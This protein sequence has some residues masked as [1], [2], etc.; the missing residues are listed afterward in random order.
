MD[1]RNES[2]NRSENASHRKGDFLGMHIALQKSPLVALS[3]ALESR[4]SHRGLQKHIASQICI[5]RFG[6]L[7]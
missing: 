7:G 5:A 4:D 6:E 2:T 3:K 1:F